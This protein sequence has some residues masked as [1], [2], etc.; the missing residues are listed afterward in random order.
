MTRRVYAVD[1]ADDE[2]VTL[3]GFGSYVGEAGIGELGE[4]FVTP[5]IVL[6]DG[7]TVY[8]FQCWWADEA[9]WESFVAGRRVISPGSR[10]RRGE[11]VSTEKRVI[12]PERLAAAL[13]YAWNDWCLD[14]GCIPDGFHIHGP[15]TTRVIP[16]DFDAGRSFVRSV[17]SWY[18][19]NVEASVATGETK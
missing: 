16:V 18:E 7:R 2:T 8:G 4:F 11:A 1:C 13:Q 5:E 14:T 6:D 3:L 17:C 12:D 15:R 9:E 10:R 19:A